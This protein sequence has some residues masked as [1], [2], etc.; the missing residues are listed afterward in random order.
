[1][2]CR[3]RL[4]ALSAAA[5]G[6]AVLGVTGQAAAIGVTPSVTT[7]GSYGYSVGSCDIA[8]DQVVNG[9]VTASA[10]QTIPVAGNTFS[11][12][13]P[14][15]AG[16]STAT[17]SSQDN[18][19]LI[20][21]TATANPD[22]TTGDVD[23]AYAYTYLTFYIT[24]VGGTPG[25]LVPVQ[26]TAA[27]NATGQTDPTVGVFGLIGLATGHENLNIFDSFNELQPNYYIWSD[28]DLNVNVNLIDGALYTVR[29]TVYATAAVYGQ[30]SSIS[31]TATADPTFTVPQ[32]YGVAVSP[33]LTSLTPTPADFPPTF[34]TPPHR[35]L[36]GLPEPGTWTLA[37]MGF[38][39]AGGS[40][41]RRRAAAA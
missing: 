23:S 33:G 9:S 25:A 41:R 8:C 39:L 36:P 27:M 34:Y 11:L 38:G 19:L 22:G 30:G 6:M 4:L 15:F 5:A 35:P 12:S 17:S 14:T 16:S 31:A 2:T 20:T 32:G 10:S 21:A 40:L 24:P 1:M 29:E 7:T 26:V 37:L 3:K 18:P 13:A 28:Q